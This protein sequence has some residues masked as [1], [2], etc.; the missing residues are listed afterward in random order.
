MV[1]ELYP[2][3]GTYYDEVQIEYGTLPP[4]SREEDFIEQFGDK[5]VIWKLNG[6]GGIIHTGRL[7]WWGLKDG[8]ALPG[9][10]GGSL[11]AMW[12]KE[13]GVALLGRQRGYAGNTPDTWE[14]MP[15]WAVQH[16]WGVKD[17]VQYSSARQKYPKNSVIIDDENAMVMVGGF[18]EPESEI[19]YNRKF[20]ISADGLQV[21]LDVD[22]D[23]FDELWESF[24]L[25]LGEDP[26]LGRIQFQVG[27]V[28][29]D[30]TTEPV[31]AT[32]ASLNRDGHVMLVRFEQPEMVRLSDEVWST[33]QEVAEDRIRSVMIDV[34]GTGKA[35][36]TF[37]GPH[38]M[39]VI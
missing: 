11:C 10:S 29:V 28:W 14:N 34:S 1:W 20:D 37:T 3:S 17:G 33:E 27:G 32:A 12:S 39:E 5:F 25:Y 22:A 2:E 18:M 13:T 36:Y 35:R 9:L 15:T 21:S 30:A 4:F 26:G 7:S 16:V 24:P 23:G 38:T 6:F 31:E 19:A 8:V